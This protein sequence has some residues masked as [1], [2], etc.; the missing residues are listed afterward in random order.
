MRKISIIDPVGIK[1]GLDLY[2]LCLAK[3]LVKQDC[4]VSI[5]SNFEG[6]VFNVHIRKVFDF[7]VRNSLI[8]ATRIML[9]IF[10]VLK[11]EKSQH[12]DV[13]ILHVFHSSLFDYLIISQ[14]AKLGFTVCIIL[15]DIE[16][17]V[18]AN[19][20]SWL[21]QCTAKC[22]RIVVH[23]LSS[24]EELK[25]RI[26]RNSMKK[27]SVLPH[28]N[29]VDEAVRISR[30]DCLVRFGL[31]EGD[32]FI[33]FF[34]MIK[35]S[36]GLEVAIEALAELPSRFHLVVAGRIRD[37]DFEYFRERI[38]RLNLNARVHEI[39]RYISNEERRM[40]FSIADVAVLPYSRI[41][42]SGVAVY[43]MSNGIPVIASALPA[44]REMISDGI[45]GLL[46]EPG[47]AG[48]LAKRITE[49]VNRD[50]FSKSLADKAQKFM[51][52]EHNWDEISKL[53]LKEL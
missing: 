32:A 52:V 34:G 11:K 50:D 3:G 4:E 38:R 9:R 49:V 22:S 37:V 36:K 48:E 35:K 44:F 27:V 39:I 47:N 41:Y 8:A 31:K 2:D 17:L 40:L 12:T 33:L 45:N 28:G 29:Y 1:A 18:F 46:F 21:S 43:A 5:F 13:I 42:Q 19:R 15:H 7:H 53:L 10:R 30:S 16:S 25:K 23:N 51:Q 20:K 6:D 26:S 24:F 14:A